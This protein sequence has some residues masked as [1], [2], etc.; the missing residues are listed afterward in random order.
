CARRD[1]Y[2]G[3]VPAWFAYW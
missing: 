3:R 1:D 2:Y